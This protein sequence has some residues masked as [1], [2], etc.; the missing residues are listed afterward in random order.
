MGINPFHA[1]GIGKQYIFYLKDLELLKEYS[2]IYLDYNIYRFFWE[3]S[4]GYNSK[5]TWTMNFRFLG[6]VVLAISHLLMEFHCIKEG[7]SAVLFCFSLSLL[8][9]YLLFWGLGLVVSHH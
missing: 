9:F 8:F 6:L 3:I 4:M 7:G 5:I 1:I 2:A